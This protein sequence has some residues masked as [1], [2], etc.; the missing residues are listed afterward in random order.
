MLQIM[1]MMVCGIIIGR[2]LRHRKLRWLSPLTTVL[3]WIL[4]FLLGLEVGG[5]QTILHSISRL[6]KDALLLAAGGAVG[7]AVAAN[8]LWHYAGKSKGGQE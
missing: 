2:T 6:G 5:D 4:L 3:I 8:R 7:S 1:L